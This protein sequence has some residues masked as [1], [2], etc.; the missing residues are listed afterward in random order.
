L[1]GGIYWV[2]LNWL[3]NDRDPEL[4]RDPLAIVGILLLFAIIGYVAEGLLGT[5]LLCW[6]R[7][8]GY[9]SLPS[10]LWG[11]FAIGVIVWV[12]PLLLFFLVL[13]ER[14]LFY[15][16]IAVLVGSVVPTL[17]STIVFWF[18]AGRQI[19]NRWTRDRNRKEDGGRIKD[20]RTDLKS[21]FILHP[22]LGAPLILSSMKLVF[23]LIISLCALSLARAQPKSATLTSAPKEARESSTSLSFDAANDLIVINVMI[24][25]QGPFRFLLDTGA[26]HHVMTPELA[27][28][29]GL[30]IESGAALDAG[31]QGTASAGLTQVAELR[32]GNFTLEQQTF[33]ITPFP[34]AYTFQGFIGAEVFKRFIIHLNFQRSLV[35]LTTP[36]G[37]RYQGKGVTIP[38]KLHQGLLPQVQA[39]VDGSGGWFKI[40]SGYNGTLALFAKFIDEHKLLSK[41]EPRADGSGARTLT[42][43]FQNLPIAK[44]REFKLGKV[45]QVDVLTSF[46]LE[47]GGSNSM[48]A[49]AIGTGILKRFNV[50]LNYQERYMI[51]EEP[52]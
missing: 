19:T 26:S 46:F 43:E 23:A 41:Y 36:Q 34:A 3:L 17:L 11:G 51:L 48:F 9:S 49:G 50:V 13:R 52:G 7:R 32:I 47:R 1:A 14:S 5:P 40:D 33:L 24:N 25:G 10:F 30:K 31:A 42:A 22:L 27:Q 12:Y 37:F 29:L 4:L 18:I 38:I 15:N 28:R 45:R 6:F 20:E 44:I 8:R 35:T 39:N 2:V 16:V 21:V